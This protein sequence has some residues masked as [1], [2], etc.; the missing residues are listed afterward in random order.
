MARRQGLPN[1]I[2]N[3]IA[4]ARFLLFL[5]LLVAGIGAA[6]QM[7]EWRRAVMLGFDGAALVF[8]LS[9]APLLRSSKPAE[10]RRQARENGANRALLLVVTAVVTTAVLVTVAAE[11]G[12][13]AEGASPLL[14]M[15]TVVIAWLFG[16]AMFTLHYAH[17]Y[18]LEGTAGDHGGLAFPATAEPGYW[19]FVYYA[20]TIGMTFQTSD[21]TIESG[22]MRRATTGHGLIAFFYNLGI[23]AFTIN[24][25]GR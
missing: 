2:G 13:A 10:M 9:C 21:V 8:L 17:L 15:G 19:D 16:N 5:L 23:L 20:F 22:R 7:A 12:S 1:T 18:Y 4:P 14:I 25:L 3:R 6:W 24:V 11:L